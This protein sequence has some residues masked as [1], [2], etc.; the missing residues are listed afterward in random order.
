MFAFS[1]ALELPSIR[2][3]RR[4]WLA[5]LAFAVGAVV[6]WPFALALAIPFVLEEL[7][8]FGADRVVP[9]AYRSWIYRRWIRLVTVGS[10]AALIFVSPADFF[11]KFLLIPPYQSSF[12]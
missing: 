1:Y 9:E 3:P 6:G 11:I 4:T 5:T 7:L 12:P 10:V 2:N 8:V